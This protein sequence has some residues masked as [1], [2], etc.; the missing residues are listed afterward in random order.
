[1]DVG[2]AEEAAEVVELVLLLPPPPDKENLKVP[3]ICFAHMGYNSGTILM[4]LHG[5][6]KSCLHVV[7]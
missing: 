1:M 5:L 2:L 3:N 4:N 7:Q 6:S